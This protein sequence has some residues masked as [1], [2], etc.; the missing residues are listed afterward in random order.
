MQA[1]AGTTLTAP[2]PPDI[3]GAVGRLCRNLLR[4]GETRRATE[5]PGG[6][7]KVE[8]GPIRPVTDPFWLSGL[9]TTGPVIL[10]IGP[11]LRGG[12][13]LLT[14]L[15]ALSCSCVSWERQAERYADL[16]VERYV[17]VH[18][19]GRGDWEPLVEFAAWKQELGFTVEWLAFDTELPPAERFQHVSL[20]L[21]RL[22][23]TGEESAYLLI[24]ATHE[25]LPMGPW[26]PRGGREEI[27]SDLPL[28]AGRKELGGT[29]D[30]S[31]WTPALAFPPPWIA[32]RLP[33]LHEEEVAT[34]LE[35]ARSMVERT[36][37]RR[38]LLGT[39]RFFLPSDSALVMAGVRN[40]LARGDWET[41]L[42]NEDAP[43][44][45]PLD[46]LDATAKQKDRDGNVVSSD[47][48]HFAFIHS[49]ASESP[50]LVYLISH[51][52]GLSA[53]VGGTGEKL[54][55]TGTGRRL[56]DPLSFLYWNTG[57]TVE[58]LGLQ[59]HPDEPAILLTTGCRMGMPDNP[60]LGLLVRG[61]WT[62][63]ICTGTHDNKPLPLF[64]ALRAERTA[65]RYLAAGLSVG[66]A[67]HAAM[68]GYLRDSVTDPLA[69]ILSP[70]TWEART[71]NALGITVYGDPSISITL[72]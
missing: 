14:A 43:R 27:F 72:R 49:W 51:S 48:V 53:E 52:R 35:S 62:A 47:P 37:T 2:P 54:D 26:I 29:L 50:D 57:D 67:F 32:G 66:A 13:V 17:I 20:E 34:A 11:P 44:E 12:K 8:L 9:V 5:G 1:E 6:I 30:R 45:H 28:L 21:A 63:T 18:A 16:A 25:E 24:V 39:E 42:Y 69:W 23:P 59:T 7:P 65:P 60:L 40:D 71:Y 33:F 56:L 70:W 19:E 38:A 22:R 68:N 15:A 41:Y 10:P 46:R 3:R 4:R 64:A 58:K 61:G 36:G 55:F 31:D